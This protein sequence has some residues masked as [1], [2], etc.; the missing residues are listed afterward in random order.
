MI[1]GNGVQAPAGS[2]A[3]KGV[4]PGLPLT[5]GCL[6]LLLYSLPSLLSR[7]NNIESFFY[8]SP[9]NGDLRSPGVSNYEGTS[10]SILFVID[11]C[12]PPSP[13]V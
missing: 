1:I 9:L 11:V 12:A 7:G 13:I 2:P 5:A 4:R 6:F 3:V 8:L 10:I